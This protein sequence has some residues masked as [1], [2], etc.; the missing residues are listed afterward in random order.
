[1]ATNKAKQL[2]KAIGVDN[3]EDVLRDA[4]TIADFGKSMNQAI[5]VGKRATQTLQ[6]M[7]R[8]NPDEEIKAMGIDP[9]ALARMHD[10]I[11]SFE[12][13]M[14]NFV[15]A[16]S[17][18]YQKL[19]MFDGTMIEV[20][21]GDIACMTGSMYKSHVLQK[22]TLVP[23]KVK[24]AD[25]YHPYKGQDLNGKKLFVWRSG[26]IGDL[27]F[28]RPI[29]MAFKEK[30]DV[31]IIF[32]TRT[33]YH[34]MVEQWDDCIDQL[35][36]VPFLVN[37]TLEQ[38]DYHITFEG[39]IERCRAAEEID[40]HDLFARHSYINVEKWN[41][42][43]KCICK[44]NVFSML[45]KKYAVL[46]L[47]A[48][49]N[50]RSPFFGNLLPIANHITE[51]MDLIISGSPRERR[52]IDDFTTCCKD[53]SRIINFSYHTGSIVDAVK[54]VTNAR[55]VVAPDSS[56]VHMAG[57]QGVPCVGLYGPFP[58][59]T[60]ATHYENFIGIEP[61]ES[62]VC[63]FG[64]KGCFKH[65]HL[66]CDYRSGC[67]ANLDHNKAIDAINQLMEW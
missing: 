25:V 32:A 53:P 33:K 34:A 27:I 63:E 17:I 60:R 18:A 61:E 16:E 7:Q 1:M 15:C 59:K 38:A 19:K 66:K 64:G 35:T 9:K 28:I 67:W 21:K 20:E 5:G 6:S 30:Y 29:L 44:N 50:V 3:P 54:L 13:E 56:H 4:Q 57:T 24:F 10:D 11:T 12:T 62:D 36:S 23:A 8:R 46:Q 58:W 42:P 47:G 49:A 39:I 26:G 22:P 40:V 43:M 2:L 41:R 37:E 45:P 51:H 52:M 31:E 65:A 14:P 48:S 55:L